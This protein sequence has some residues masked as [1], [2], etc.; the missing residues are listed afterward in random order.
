[1]ITDLVGGTLQWIRGG[2]RD[3]MRT[4]M[5]MLAMVVREEVSLLQ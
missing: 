5:G 3:D 2:S 1:M 4:Q